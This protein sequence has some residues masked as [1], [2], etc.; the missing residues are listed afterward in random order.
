MALGKF[1]KRAAKG[2]LRTSGKIVG[3]GAKSAIAT[4][5]LGPAAGAMVTQR[6]LQKGLSSRQRKKL[7]R[8]QPVY[9]PMG[10][11]A[12]LATPGYKN[13]EFTGGVVDAN[14]DILPDPGAQFPFM[15]GMNPAA[16]SGAD[17]YPVGGMA[18]G[19][20]TNKYGQPVTVTAG[21]ET[22]M[23]CPRGYVAVT[24]P[25]GA[26]A[27]M[28]RSAAIAM[29]LWKPRAKPPISSKDWKAIRSMGR[30]QDRLK[31]LNSTA[32]LKRP[33]AKRK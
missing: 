32:G 33:V 21:Y 2:T 1:L 13:Q 4:A 11:A 19:Q 31:D 24:L 10:P 14:Y 6:E 29:R 7:Q 17:L 15:A 20:A 26:R 16:T 8:G 23:R 30:I 25:N 12:K 5:A 28:L 27:C 9:P 22:R 3:I 18:V